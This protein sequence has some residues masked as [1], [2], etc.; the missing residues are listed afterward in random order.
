[1]QSHLGGE[2]LYLA[3]SLPWQGIETPLADAQR[4]DVGTLAKSLISLK[5]PKQSQDP[6]KINL[7]V[8]GEIC[9]EQHLSL[10]DELDSLDS[11]LSIALLLG[12]I[13]RALVLRYL[14]LENVHLVER[15]EALLV[16][17]EEWRSDNLA[18]TW[19]YISCA[20]QT[21]ELADLDLVFPIGERLAKRGLISEDRRRQLQL[22]F[23]EAVTN[24]IEHGNLELISEWKEEVGSD[25]IDRFSIERRQR[26]AD[27]L[28]NQRKLS[29]T[30][31]F[32]GGEVTIEVEDEG[33]GFNYGKVFEEL[34]CPDQ[35]LP[36]GRGLAIISRLSDGFCYDK[37]GCRLSMSFRVCDSQCG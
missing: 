22:A 18:E 13:P 32:E 34:G 24:G 8:V 16:L 36:F 25:G 7:L 23:Q 28:Y 31:R 33:S 2:V 35:E 19:R 5:E 17:L 1:M 9:Q 15:A 37:G 4:I 10:L 29:I 20:F 26:L 21:G 27:Q 11:D 6:E 30:S 12:S 14:C 3:G